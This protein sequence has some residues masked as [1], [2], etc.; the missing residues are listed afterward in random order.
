[1]YNL[2]VSVNVTNEDDVWTFRPIYTFARTIT[3]GGGQTDI[4]TTV[5]LYARHV[6]LQP[7]VRLN[8]R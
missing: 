5:Y 8:L 3:T 6:P 1:M 2:L 7:P 4:I